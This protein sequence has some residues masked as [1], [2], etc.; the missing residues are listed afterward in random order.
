MKICLRTIPPPTLSCP[1]LTDDEAHTLHHGYAFSEGTNGEQEC[2]TKPEPD[3]LGA[4]SF[5]THNHGERRP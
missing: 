5:L 4:Q 2:V 1:H 3:P